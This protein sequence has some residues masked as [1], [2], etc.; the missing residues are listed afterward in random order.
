[1]NVLV[2]KTIIP[3][4]Y[5]V[6]MIVNADLHIHSRFSMAVSQ[7]MILSVLSKEATKKGV[8]LV[9]TGDCLHPA[10]L[11]E[12]KEM[13]KADEGTFELNK[14]RFILTTELEDTMRVHHL[15]FFPSISS[16]EDFIRKI[17]NKTNL[18]IDGRPKLCLDGDQIAEY[19]KEVGALIGPSHAFTPWTAIYAYHNS[20]ES[21]YGD[22]T[23]YVSFAELGLSADSDYA[24]R[25]KELGRLTF[26]TNSDAHSPYPL[27]LAREF[28][29]F[30]V[31]EANFENIKNAILRKKGKIVLNVGLP[32]QEGK[33]NESACIK[34]YKHYLLMEAVMKK[35]RCPCGGTI[36]K[37]VKDRV[38]ELSDYPEPVHPDYRPRYLHL[39]PLAEIIAKAMDT[40]PL[41]KTVFAE[42]NNLI[43]KFGNE[44]N[45][46][47][48]APMDEIRESTNERIA[49]AITA[50]RGNRV[51]IHPGGG[52][53]YGMIELSV[54]EAKQAHKTVKGQKSLFDF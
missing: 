38:E 37:G 26:L 41:T 51:I 28:N 23:G 36:K 46:L 10:W 18:E 50:F 15:L 6:L 20:L 19:A 44:V 2:Q 9:G 11:K 25:I 54:D 5:P 13:Q 47:V 33:Y 29:R 27:R 39:I 43:K 35:W 24:D 31:E 3:Y 40:T 12:I 34:C 42:W 1:M 30:D 14:T 16:V 52:G 45:V 21:C 17:K 22:L 49:D 48:D 4:S 8:S 32:P 7:K 53:R